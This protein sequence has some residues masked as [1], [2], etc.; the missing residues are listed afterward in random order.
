MPYKSSGH[1]VATEKRT[2]S[3][4]EQLR[5]EGIDVGEELEFCQAEPKG[6]PLQIYLRDRYGQ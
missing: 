3:C 1:K 5:A 2:Q 6:A 4:L